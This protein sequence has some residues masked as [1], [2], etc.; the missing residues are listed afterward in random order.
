MNIFSIYQKKIII[1]LR[2]L[3]K[4][5]LIKIPAN[6]SGVVVELP[7]KNQKADI[8]CN[9]AMVLAKTNNT[10]PINLAEILKKHLLLNFKEFKDIEIVSPGFINIFVRSKI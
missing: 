8:S 2:K 9:A 10:S 1:I 5:K 4:K 7:P 6:I 3:S